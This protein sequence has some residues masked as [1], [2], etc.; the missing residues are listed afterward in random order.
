MQITLI[1]A[2]WVLA[3][4]GLAMGANPA[5]VPNYSHLTV[6]FALPGANPYTYN[7]FI[8]QIRNQLRGGTSANIPVLRSSL[9]VPPAHRF[10]F[11]KL[12]NYS[13]QSVTLVVD[14]TNVYVVGY[15]SSMNRFYFFK[16]AP[17]QINQL[18]PGIVK[19]P[20]GFAESYA[21][22]QR[23]SGEKR[24]K[25]LL[26]LTPLDQALS[27]LFNTPYTRDI[28]YVA[29]SLTIVKQLVS[30]SVRF[31]YIKNKVEESIKSNK[32]FLPDPQVT[33]YEN[34]WEK[35]SKAVQAGN[36]NHLKPPV[37][38]KNAQNKHY[39]VQHVWELTGRLSLMLFAKP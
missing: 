21:D 36:G 39:F 18:F 32:Q 22:L 23:V 17:I 27:T 9:A 16:D 29:R 33:S 7:Q 19:K 6:T 13:H 15:V 37:Q 38:L 34:N 8:Q 10:L 14:V 5:P 25:I 24:E 20:L 4:V 28:K 2:V 26:G 30:E 31:E 3:N 1:A 12:I 35:L 11:V